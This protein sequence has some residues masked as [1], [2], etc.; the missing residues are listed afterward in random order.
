MQA[1]DA[2]GNLL[3]AAGPFT[4]PAYVPPPTEKPKDGDDGG[5]GTGGSGGGPGFGGG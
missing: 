5:D 1:L 3:C 2:A 4:K